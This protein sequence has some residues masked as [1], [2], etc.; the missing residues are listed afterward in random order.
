MALPKLASFINTLDTLQD[1]VQPKYMLY[2]NG[3]L[4][5]RAIVTQPHTMSQ[6]WLYS[7]SIDGTDQ[8]HNR[9][10]RGTDLAEITDNLKKLKSSSS[11]TVLIWSTLREKQSLSDCFDEF[12][13]LHSSGLADQ[14]FWHWVETPHPFADL[15]EYAEQYERDLKHILAEYVHWIE[16]GRILPITHL[17]ELFCYLLSGQERKS[18]ACGVELADS[19]DILDG[20]VHCCAD[21]P[22]EMFIGHIDAAGIPHIAERNLT[23]LV[24]YKDDL[25][26]QRCTIHSYCGGRCPVQALTSEAERLV[27]YCQLI[28]IHVGVCLD[29]LP[30]VHVAM[31]KNNITIQQLYDESA[32]YNQFTD[33]TP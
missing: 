29:F 20:K 33:I 22:P 15:A 10:R 8:Q 30:A 24:S 9:F 3:M 31:T 4:L 21:L 27:Q 26:C 12:T 1:H 23:P 11:S 14:F 32:Y 7:L 16:Q 5:D 25:G 19:Y 2:T 6:I 17:N 28:R 18:S 13:H